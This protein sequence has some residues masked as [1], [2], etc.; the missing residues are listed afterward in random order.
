MQDATPKHS[1]TEWVLCSDDWQDIV[2]T[3]VSQ[4]SDT[5]FQ[6]NYVG[7]SL[8]EIKDAYFKNFHPQNWKRTH[9]K[10][11]KFKSI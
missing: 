7:I 3:Y 1:Q 9:W 2:I 6:D 8:K 11:S 10:Q 4:L 5:P